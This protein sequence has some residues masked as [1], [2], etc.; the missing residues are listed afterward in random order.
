MRNLKVT[1]WRDLGKF[2]ERF[3]WWTNLSTALNPIRGNRVAYDIA[4]GLV[5]FQRG[6]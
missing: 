6:T 4:M 2:S 1:L 3:D 5:E